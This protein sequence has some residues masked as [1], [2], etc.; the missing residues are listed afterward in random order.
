[1]K[2]IYSHGGY[3]R[4]FARCA[5]DDYSAEE[6]HFVD[7]APGEG[8]I[9]YEQALALDPKRQASFVIGFAGAALRRQKTAQ[10]M[11]D[12]FGVFDVCAATAVIGDNVQV[13]P[14]SVI[15]DFCILTSDL[16]TGPSFQC[17]IYSYVAHDCRVGSYV[18][19][20]PRVSVNGRVVIEDNV[21]VGTGATIL[22]GTADKPMVIG[23]GAIIGAHALV[24]RDVEP[25]ATVIGSPAKPLRKDA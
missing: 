25:G 3:A 9:S 6:I 23:A 22:P 13:G 8:A 11:S 15:S 21:Y 19:L 17:N 4:E 10:V 7:D 20:A 1:M 2:F 18:T 12:G 16:E 5:R 14:G 24:T